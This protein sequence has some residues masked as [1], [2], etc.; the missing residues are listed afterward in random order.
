MPTVLEALGI[1]P[2]AGL[3]FAGESLLDLLDRDEGTAR[4]AYSES[5]NDLIAYQTL[6]SNAESLYAV[7]DGRWKLI[8]HRKDGRYTRFELY[9]L[10]NDPKELADLFQA[11][12]GHARRLLEQ[13]EGLDPYLDLPK[14]GALEPEVRERLRSL[15]YVE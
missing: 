5:V 7:N 2:P 8:A 12:P 11:R 1:H 13:L 14:P 10:V 15:G 9:D 6:P 3:T 4:F